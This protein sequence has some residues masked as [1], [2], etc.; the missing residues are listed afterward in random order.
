MIYFIDSHLFF[1]WRG[2]IKNIMATILLNSKADDLKTITIK[3][4]LSFSHNA[5]Y[6]SE[7]N[8]W[9][10]AGVVG[11]LI[12]HTYCDDIRSIESDRYL[13]TDCTVIGENFGTADFN[14][15]Y[16]FVAEKITVLNDPLST[17]EIKEIEDRVYAYEKTDKFMY[18][19]G[20]DEDGED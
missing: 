18:G 19:I 5:Q 11:E 6:D 12:T 10:D 14:I 16:K 15:V 2:N 3:G 7:N 8:E 17:E 1:I 9:V 4:N 20:K 13:I